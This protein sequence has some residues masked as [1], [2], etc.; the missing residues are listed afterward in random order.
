[1]I[2]YTLKQH[3][4]LLPVLRLTEVTMTENSLR[5]AGKILVLVKL[6]ALTMYAKADLLRPRTSITADSINR[7]SNML[8]FDV[9]NMSNSFKV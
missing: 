1:M 3:C 2:Y 4:W 7:N 9:I 6:M 8:E 5:L